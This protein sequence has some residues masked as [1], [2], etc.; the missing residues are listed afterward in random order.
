MNDLICKQWLKTE[1]RMP[2]VLRH[3]IDNGMAVLA[4]AK[5]SQ[6]DTNVTGDI[7]ALISSRAQA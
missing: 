7:A 4:N 5:S 2:R 3:R 6:N 1:C